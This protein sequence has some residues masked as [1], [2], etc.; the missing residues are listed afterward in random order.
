[1]A[2]L[3]GRASASIAAPLIFEIGTTKAVHPSVIEAMLYMFASD[4][5]EPEKDAASEELA[6]GELKSSRVSNLN[7]LADGPVVVAALDRYE[8][9]VRNR[10]RECARVAVRDNVVVCSRKDIDWSLVAF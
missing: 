10:V 6:T 5:A 7:L 3:E 2:P 8:P 1:M 4:A 9:G